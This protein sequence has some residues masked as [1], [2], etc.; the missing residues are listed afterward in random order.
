MK[1]FIKILGILFALVFILIVSGYIYL[2]KEYP[3]IDKA[4]DIKIEPTAERIEKGKYLFN[5]VYLCVD[6]HSKR[7]FSKLSGPVVPGTEGAGG[8]RFGEELG[9]PGTVYSKNITPAGVGDWTDG[10]LFR[11]ITEGVSKDGEPLFPLMPYLVYGTKDKE[12]IYSIIAYMRT[13]PP[14]K[15]DIPKKDLDFPMNLIVRT[16]P[17]KSN[18]TQRPDTTDKIALGKYYADACNDCHTPSEKGKFNMDK[19]LAGGMEV[20]MPGNKVVRSANLTPDMETG[21]GS[22]TR[23]QFIQRFKMCSTPEYKNINV[24]EGEFNSF[25]PWTLFANMKEEDLGAIYDYLRTVKPIKNKIEKFG[26]KSKY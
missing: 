4:L 24:K 13:L 11:A 23:E 12:D 14:I 18:F 26:E 25:M 17:Q 7:D 8:Q 10:E 9:L 19:Y 6:C 21:L 15:N 16:V 3:Q 2:N 5:S 1:K 20:T 22:W